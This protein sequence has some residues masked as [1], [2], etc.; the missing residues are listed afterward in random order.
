MLCDTSIRESSVDA[1]GTRS[2]TCVAN[3]SHVS[4]IDVSIIRLEICLV[5]VLGHI[6]MRRQD[7]KGRLA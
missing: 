5:L 4:A 7:W 2:I 3:R 6:G 1:L